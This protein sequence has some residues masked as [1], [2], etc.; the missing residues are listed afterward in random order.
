MPMN[1]DISRRS[2]YFFLTHPREGLHHPIECLAHLNAYD[3]IR[4]VRRGAAEDAALVANL[5]DSELIGDPPAP[6]EP[7]GERFGGA[8]NHLACCP[9]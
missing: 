7:H 1:A 4:G 5:L 6:S 9:A 8:A 2:R 3:L